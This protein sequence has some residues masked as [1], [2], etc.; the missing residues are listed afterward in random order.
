MT[1]SAPS[2]TLAATLH[3][4]ADVMQQVLG[5][6]IVLLDMKGEQYFGLDPVGARIWTL[7]DGR[8]S[9]ED[10][11]AMLHAEYDADRDVLGSDL[12]LLA[13]SLLDA[14]LVAAA[15]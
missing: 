9:L 1:A 14:G 8:R 5:D 10:V 12:L 13:Q 7:L 6:E 11:L 15:R 2:V 4:S 3:R